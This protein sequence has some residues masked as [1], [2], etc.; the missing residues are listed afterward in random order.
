MSTDASELPKLLT[1]EEALSY[2]RIGRTTFYKLV[3]RRELV[4]TKIGNRTF[5][6]SAEILKFLARNSDGSR[7]KEMVQ[8]ENRCRPFFV[9]RPMSSGTA[10]SPNCDS[11]LSR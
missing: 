3:E 6:S 10:K 4:P 11:V 5:I 2:L 9:G 7:V 1:V 8:T